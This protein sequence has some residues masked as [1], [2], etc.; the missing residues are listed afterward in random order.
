M[1]V[2]IVVSHGPTQTLNHETSEPGKKAGRLNVPRGYMG[3]Y[4]TSTKLLRRAWSSPEN[5]DRSCTTRTDARSSSSAPSSSFVPCPLLVDLGCKDRGRRG[6]REA[7]W[8]LRAMKPAAELGCKSRREGTGVAGTS[9]QR[10]SQSVLPLLL[11]LS[12]PFSSD[13]F[14]LPPSVLAG[15]D[16]ARHEA[17]AASSAVDPRVTT[18]AS[19]SARR[20]AS[21][22]KTAS[23]GHYR[24]ASS[25]W[26][27]CRVCCVS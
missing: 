20:H 4:R 10:R 22:G 13:A 27:H 8:F 6:G 25:S 3:F 7:A 18:M 9:T 15:L 5:R 12:F 21:V 2:V 24:P 17:A 26:P 1:L 11:L 14:V 23:L 16:R 19:P